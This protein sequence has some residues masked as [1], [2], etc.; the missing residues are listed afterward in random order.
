[1][2]AHTVSVRVFTSPPVPDGREGSFDFAFTYTVR[3]E[4]RG[5]PACDTWSLRVDGANGGSAE[6]HGGAVQTFDG[7]GSVPSE[8]FAQLVGTAT[9]KAG[10]H[11]VT[12]Q[13][14]PTFVEGPAVPD[15]PAEQRV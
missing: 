2:A 4:V 11:A 15:E 8:R 1:M 13:S 6:R 10:G 14:E 12:G 5:T 7:S 3:A 9:C